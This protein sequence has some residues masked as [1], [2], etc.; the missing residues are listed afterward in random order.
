M[1]FTCS[2]QNICGRQSTLLRSIHQ[3][4]FTCTAPNICGKQRT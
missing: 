3:Q 2:A 1:K 4:K